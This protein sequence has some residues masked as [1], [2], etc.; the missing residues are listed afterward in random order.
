MYES[1]YRYMSGTCTST[2]VFVDAY[3][4]VI[5]VSGCVVDLE[6]YLISINF[7]TTIL[8]SECAGFIDVYIAY[9]KQSKL[10]ELELDGY[11]YVYFYIVFNFLFVKIIFALCV[12][13]VQRAL[14]R[15]IAL[16]A[17][18]SNGAPA[19]RARERVR[20]RVRGLT[21]LPAN[22]SD[23]SR[24]LQALFEARLRKHLS[25]GVQHEQ[26]VTF[27]HLNTDQEHKLSLIHSLTQS[28]FLSLSLHTHTHTPQFSYKH[29]HLY[30][31]IHEDKP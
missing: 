1:M 12:K 30:Y 16:H 27:N 3:K 11:T 31:D 6:S 4:F 9:L 19:I 29:T 18:Q 23:V 21:G 26:D 8:Y 17:R 13:L 25:S 24:E 5:C 20:G 14:H 7:F 28:F 22:E 15:L 10:S 2:A